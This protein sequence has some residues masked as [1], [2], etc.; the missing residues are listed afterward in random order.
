MMEH[1]SH[2]ATRLIALLVAVPLS[3]CRSASREGIRKNRAADKDPRKNGNDRP[4][5]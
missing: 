3:G 2:P 4:G 5:N 1:G